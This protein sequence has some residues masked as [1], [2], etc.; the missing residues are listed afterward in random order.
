MSINS[1]ERNMKLI[2]HRGTNQI[3]GCITEIS[4]NTTRIFI[5]MGE[6]LPGFGKPLNEDEKK[7]YVESLFSQNQQQNEAVIY[8]HGHSDHI[9]MMQYVPQNVKQ[10]MSKGTQD[11]LL[12]KQEVLKA[13]I[14]LSKPK[15]TSI[16]SSNELSTESPKDLSNE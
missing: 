1:K 4:T 6:N 13:G 10:Y 5:D 14:E 15:E 12:I 2:I 9:G 7:E 16:K 11:S 3:G 8:T